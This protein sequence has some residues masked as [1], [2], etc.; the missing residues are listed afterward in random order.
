MKTVLKVILTVVLVVVLYFMFI[1]QNELEVKIHN[2]SDKDISG[3][4]LVTNHSLLLVDV[5]T[6]KAGE[7]EKFTIELPE[8]FDEG[9]IDLFYVD[10]QGVQHSEVIHGYVE[11]GYVGLGEVDIRSVDKDGVIKMDI[12]AETN[13]F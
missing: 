3:L 2:G 8:D 13:I 9:S 4:Q 6:I 7:K 10:K 5:G 11:R 1:R 12:E